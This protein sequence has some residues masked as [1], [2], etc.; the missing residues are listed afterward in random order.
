MKKQFIYSFEWDPEKARRNLR[1]HRIPFERGATVFQ[2]PNALSL[3]DDDHS[4]D[5]D[6]W[7]TL[8]QD[9]TGIILVIS[10]TYREE[11][12]AHITIRIIS[13]RKATRKE[14]NNYERK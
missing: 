1:D 4:D 14:Q 13:A 12:D 3:Y 6:R 7:I 11:T 5:E 10:H 8:G 2:D 9:R